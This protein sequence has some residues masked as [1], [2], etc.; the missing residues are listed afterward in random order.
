MPPQDKLPKDAT[1][2]IH[3]GL[4]VTESIDASATPEWAIGPY[5]L[6]RRLGESGIDEV[7]LA[8]KKE[9]L[10]RWEAG[11]DADLESP[12]GD[13]RFDPLLAAARRLERRH[14]S[15]LRRIRHAHGG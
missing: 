8:E 5:H 2:A 3:P 10:R 1:G 13:P 11:N 6:I 14:P 7:W 4:A 9:A 12:R 15:L